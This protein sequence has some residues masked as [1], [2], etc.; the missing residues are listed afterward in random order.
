MRKLGKI[1]IGIICII[2]FLFILGIFGSSNTPSLQS[3]NGT[4]YSFSYPSTWNITQE[5]NNSTSN[6]P[7][8]ELT[9]TNKS[10]DATIT[11]LDATDVPLF[12]N[13][14]TDSF[15]MNRTASSLNDC[16]NSLISLYSTVNPNEST[17]S[18]VPYPYYELLNDT[19][20][21]VNGL[22]GFD[23]LFR[24]SETGLLDDPPVYVEEVVLQ[25][26]TN[27]YELRLGYTPNITTPYA[28]N[29][30]M[31]IVNSFK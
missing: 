12:A 29:D 25:N 20:I 16:R 11:I 9:P 8:I 19:S 18:V 10:S 22:N 15:N 24:T 27:F 30:F 31:T 13:N 21:N 5:I 23:M 14:S 4:A 28:H 1:L 2:A 6:E 26:G 7:S 3:Y 17:N